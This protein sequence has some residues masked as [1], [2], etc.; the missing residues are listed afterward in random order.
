MREH[1]SERRGADDPDAG[2][3]FIGAAPIRR[4]AEDGDLVARRDQSL[5]EVPEHGFHA[6]DGRGIKRTD[7]EDSQPV[8][9]LAWIK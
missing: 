2:H 7:L 8:A 1:L 5:R 4:G 6:A 3:G 9:M